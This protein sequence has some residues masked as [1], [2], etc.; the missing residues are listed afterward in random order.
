MG[1]HPMNPIY[2]VIDTETTGL[3]DDPS[4]HVVELGAAMAINPS[5][6]WYEK[7]EYSTFCSFVKP[8]VLTPEGLAISKK[9]SGITEDQIRSAPTPDTVWRNFFIWVMR[10]FQKKGNIEYSHDPQWQ[11]VLAWNAEFDETMV[12]KTFG[13]SLLEWRC[14]MKPFTSEF[15]KWAPRRRD[16]SARYFK[17]VTAAKFAGFEWEG[18]AHRADADALMTLRLHIAR[19]GGRIEVD[20]TPRMFNPMTE[21]L[22]GKTA[23]IGAGAARHAKRGSK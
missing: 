2:L 3:P 15:E 11:S 12:K 17:L 9:I 19:L 6:N 21:R 1:T 4:A 13:P 10:E 20:A 7:G 18:K 5:P 16:G 14:A 8:P 22:E 23:L